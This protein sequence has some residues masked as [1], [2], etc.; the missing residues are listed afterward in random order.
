MKKNWMT[1]GRNFTMAALAFSVIATG[2]K[3][4]EEGE[5]PTPTPTPKK[6]ELVIDGQATTVSTAT[7]IYYG[8]FLGS[9]T[10]NFDLLIGTGTLDIN[11]A[12]ASFTGKGDLLYM[13]MFTNIATHL[14]GGTY[15]YKPMSNLGDAFSFTNGDFTKNLDIMAETLDY[16]AD[17][18]GGKV[19]VTHTPGSTATN[20]IYEFTF[21][22]SLDN[23]KK[24]TG[25]YKGALQFVDDSRTENTENTKKLGAQIR[26]M[27][28][29][30]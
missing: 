12:A 20:G 22:V 1:I 29:S 23:G 14:A 15:D 8:D 17:V 7:L 30:L 26:E 19:V 11:L 10:E 24:V 6:N 16:D 25:Y 9:G 27:A 21:D 28:G 5:T 2:C 3:K 13:E 18:N 4:D